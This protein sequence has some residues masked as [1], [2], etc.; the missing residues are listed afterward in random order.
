MLQLDLGGWSEPVS[1]ISDKYSDFV[2]YNQMI[3]SKGELFLQ[4]LRYVVGDSVMHEILQAYY[5]RWQM[6]H[7]DGAE[8]PGGGRGGLRHGPESALRRSGCMARRCSTTRW[9]RC[10]ASRRADGWL[11]RV[12]VLRKG[13]GMIPVDVAVIA[14]HDTSVVRSDGLAPKAWV[15]VTH[16]VGAQ[17]GAGR[18][19]R[20]HARLEHAEQPVS[21][22]A[23]R[24]AVP[25]GDELL[26]HLVHRTGEPGSVERGFMPAAW[27]NTAGGLVVGARAREN[28]LGMFEENQLLLSYNLGGPGDDASVQEFDYFLRLKNPVWLRAPSQSQR[29]EV[30]RTEG[31]WGGLLGWDWSRRDHLTFG[32][33]RSAGVSLRLVDIDNTAFLDPQQYID[34]G[35]VELM[36]DWGIRNRV[37]KWQLGGKLSL[38]GGLVFNRDGLAAVQPDLDPFYFRGEIEG[39]ARREIAK[40]LTFAGRIYGGVA[41]GAH[42]AAKQR[43]IYLSSSDPFAQLYNP[44]LRSEGSLLVLDDVPYQAPGGAGV[45]RSRLPD[46]GPGAHRGQRGTGAELL[47]PPEVE[48][49]SA[50]SHWRRSGMRRRASAGPTSSQPAKRS[51]SSPTPGLGSGRATGS[52]RRRSSPGSTS[53]ST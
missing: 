17:G 11:T 20:A 28:Y 27:Y 19:H 15:E 7:V 51:A 40:K 52:G 30:F 16:P 29:L 53:R 47:L 10:I 37:G 5:Q 14:E 50:G 39:T 26:R 42:T 22:H 21:L 13:D 33:T 38:G 36:T 34:A 2:V 35:I 6:K 23:V 44:F 9:A 4:Q 8:I 43:Q 18:P 12:E 48:A 31:R 41:T 24:E 45:R 46:L 32:P 3:Y 1:L 25:P 49:A